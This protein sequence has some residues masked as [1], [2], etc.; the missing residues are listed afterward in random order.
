[1][2]QPEEYAA[3]LTQVGEPMPRGLAEL[4]EFRAK[5]AEA[6]REYAENVVRAVYI[7]PKCNGHL[8]ERRKHHGN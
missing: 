2:I 3:R 7:C 1:M 8:Q 5:I 6:I 4:Y